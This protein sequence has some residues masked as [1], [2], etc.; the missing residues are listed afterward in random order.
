MNNKT[1]LPGGVQEH[2]TL[3]KEGDQ[4]YSFKVFACNEHGD[5]LASARLDAKSP[6]SLLCKL[7]SWCARTSK[8]E[9]VDVAYVVDKHDIMLTIPL[10]LWRTGT[11]DSIT[12]E[13]KDFNN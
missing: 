7:S 2:S 3:D 12:R 13:G 8:R 11:L 4:T 6:F 1:K 5:P 9:D 10:N